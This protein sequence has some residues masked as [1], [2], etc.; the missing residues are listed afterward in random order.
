M[1]TAK[2]TLSIP[3][4]VAGFGVTGL[5]LLNWRK[6]TP[7]KAPLP[8]KSKTSPGG[9]VSILFEADRVASWA[10]KHNLPFDMD[11]AVATSQSAADAQTV[12]KKAPEKKAAAKKADGKKSPKRSKA[13]ES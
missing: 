5:T 10:K 12:A 9:R 1:A 7:T 6:G 8:H 3:Q 11:K 2:S 4:V 13:L